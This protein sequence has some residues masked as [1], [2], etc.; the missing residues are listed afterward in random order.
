MAQN[1]MNKKTSLWSGVSVLIVAVLAIMAFVGG[2]MQLW[3]L[4]LAFTV[5]VIW[6]ILKHFVPCLKAWVYRHKVQKLRRQRSAQVRK[7]T[8]F[9]VPDI[10][11]PFGSVLLRH[12]SFRISS[13]LQSA[14]PDATW[15]WCEEFPEKIVAKG[16]TARIQVFGIPA[17]NYAD[18]T[19][20]QKADIACN[21]LKIVPMAELRN[22]AGETTTVPEKR[23]PIDPQVWY[24]TQAREVLEN[25]ITDLNARGHR[26]LT[27][28]DNGEV[29]IQQADTALVKPLFENVPERVY[30]PRLVKVF[31]REGIAAN[32]AE[33]G[34]V[35]S[36]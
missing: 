33:N 1:K 11:D 31:E 17:F 19:F 30:W 8:A 14:Y 12:V 26:N 16:G 21:M 34:M 4:G 10:S 32:I 23:N 7:T 2:S 15:E 35:L 9:K 3:L 25:L 24:E 27:I 6:A 5:W 13:Y 22:A 20:N 36:W 29:A 18:V 28:R